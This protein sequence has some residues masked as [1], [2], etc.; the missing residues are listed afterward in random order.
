MIGLSAVKSRSN[1][2][3]L[4]PCGPARAGREHFERVYQADA[5]PVLDRL[6]FLD[7]HLRDWVLEHAYARGY[8]GQGLDL[9]ERERLAVLALASSGC[10]KQCESHL[11]ACRRLGHGA[12]EMTDDAAAGGWLNQAQIEALRERIRGLLE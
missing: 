1:S 12:A 8:G 5:G 6:T 3:S 10:W 2:V 7:P 9:L 4:K 11:R